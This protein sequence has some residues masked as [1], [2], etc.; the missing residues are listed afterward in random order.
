LSRAVPILN[1]SDT[2]TEWLGA[3]I[4][5]TQR[6]NAEEALLLANRHK[7]EFLATLAHELRNPLAPLRNGLRIA[8]L[9]GGGSESTSFARTLDMMDR[10]VNL[11]VHLVDDL[12]D[13][14]RITSGTIQLRRARVS[15][16]EVVAASAEVSE[17]IIN[18]RGHRLI[19]IPCE[20]ELIVEGDFDRLTQVFSNLLSNASKYTEDAG[21]IT[22]QLRRE[23]QEAV[24]SVTD[25]GIGIPAHSLSNIFDMFS[26]IRSH[27]GRADGGLGIGLALVRQ[28]VGMH[29]GLVYAASPGVDQGSTFTVRLPLSETTSRA[30]A[31]DPT[32]VASNYS[33][34]PSQRV[35]IVDDNEDAASSLAE[36]LE[37][38][39]QQVATAA[40][41]QQ[42]VAKAMAVRPDIVFL[43]LGMPRMD[44]FEAARQLRALPN[45]EQMTL[46]AL[47]GWGQEYDLQRTHAAGFDHHLLKPIDPTLLQRFLLAHAE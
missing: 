17:S 44:G 47:T 25:T 22:V 5:L 12:L 15:L 11:L 14:S 19:I 40:D 33:V 38:W 34:A 20:E 29:G 23:L 30:M 26:Q 28:L 36:L 16:R 24:V 4:D 43:D 27:Q 35:L 41:G 13:I 10:Q 7:D 8:R 1:E 39:G 31:P 6:K 9:S 21:T 46:I 32:P 37:R 2:V 18:A 45:G 3:A 42:G